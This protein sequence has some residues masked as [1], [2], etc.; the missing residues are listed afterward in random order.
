VRGPF[1]GLGEFIPR[2]PREEKGKDDAAAVNSPEQL[3]IFHRQFPVE[4]KIRELTGGMLRSLGDEESQ[5][6][7]VEKSESD[8]TRALR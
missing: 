4:S 7:R 5:S 8:D 3:G 1:N 6:L 2:K